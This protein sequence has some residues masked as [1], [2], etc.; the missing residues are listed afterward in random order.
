MSK[1]S[2]SAR[3]PT[4]AVLWHGESPKLTRRPRA[5][6]WGG[7][8]KKPSWAS[9]AIDGALAP[10]SIAR[11]AIDRA[12]PRNRWDGRQIASSRGVVVGICDRADRTRWWPRAAAGNMPNPYV[13]LTVALAARARRQAGTHTSYYGR[14][15]RVRGS[16]AGAAAMRPLIT[17]AHR[18][19][20][21]SRSLGGAS[22]AMRCTCTLTDTWV[23]CG[24]LGTLGAS[25]HERRYFRV[26]VPDGPVYMTKQPYTRSSYI[27][28]SL[29]PG[30]V[31]LFGSSNAETDKQ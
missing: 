17:T 22:R 26:G 23:G 31:P 1:Y 27:N 15:Q 30:S 5:R 12:Q 8:G 20:R 19:V 18:D 9:T 11:F 28:W 21:T 4:L 24:G 14:S 13:A 16:R 7:E 3:P 25:V 6:C 2:V 29:L 10:V